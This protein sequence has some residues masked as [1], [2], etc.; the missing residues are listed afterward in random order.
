M[1][2]LIIFIGLSFSWGYAQNVQEYWLQSR[3]N[4]VYEL[5]T[6]SNVQFWGYGDNTPPN[7]GNKIFLPGPTLRFKEGDSA[8]VHF[9]NNSPEMHTIH[10]HGLDVPTA[11]DGVPHTS[12]Q[13]LPNATFDYKFKCA[14]AGTFLYHCHVLTPLHLAMGMYGMVIVDP[15]AGTGTLFE[16]GPAYQYEYPLLASE[17]DLD[18]NTNP[19]SPGPFQLFEANYLMINGKS[20]AQLLD[21]THD[22]YAQ[23]NTPMAI[24]L[25][26]IGYGKVTF[27]LPA[28]VQVAVVASDGRPLP[29]AFS[30]SQIEVYPGER[31][32]LIVSSAFVL[33]DFIEVVYEDLRDQQIMGTNQVPFNIG[34]LS[35]HQLPSESYLTLAPNPVQDIL[36][37][38]NA[39]EQ[40]LQVR[41][42]NAQGQT[43][44]EFEIPVG[45]SNQVLAVPSGLYF[46]Q[47]QFGQRLKFV[48]VGL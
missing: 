22:L 28:S 34:L 21:G 36:H 10:F 2:Q 46:L 6:G 9:Q 33:S 45:V 3:M 43:L 38:N 14:H 29:L 31:Y 4:G 44:V 41:C 32:D 16:N 20:G 18:W 19:L 26:N 30:T 39:A 11:Y 1:K 12:V 42:L 7:P 15:A 5:P 48:K 27:S 8:I 37:L 23:I 17:F 47:D 35:T 24:R 13:I 40:P 25:A